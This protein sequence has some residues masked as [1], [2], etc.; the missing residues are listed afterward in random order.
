M[1]TSDYSTTH[2]CKDCWFWFVLECNIP[3]GS[4]EDQISDEWEVDIDMI[5]SCNTTQQE[6]SINTAMQAIDEDQ[7]SLRA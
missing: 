1:F 5:M 4:W 3:L 7:V 2:L 6:T